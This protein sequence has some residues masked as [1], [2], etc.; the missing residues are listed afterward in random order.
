MLKTGGHILRH[1]RGKE[2]MLW[3][4]GDMLWSEGDLLEK[5]YWRRQVV[6]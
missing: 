2:D 6:D 5:R 1:A 3:T 4:E